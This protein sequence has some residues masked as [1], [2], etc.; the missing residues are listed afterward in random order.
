MK[1][2]NSI[3]GALLVSFPMFARVELPS[4]I[5]SGMVLQRN[6]SVMLWGKSSPYAR[7]KIDTGWDKACYRTES[8]ADGRW[9]VRVATCNAGGPYTVTISDGTPVTL[10]N[11][12]LGEVWI[13]S[14]QSNMEMP[15]KGFFNQPTAEPMEAISRAGQYPGLRLFTVPKNRSDIPLDSCGGRWLESTPRSV[16]DFSATAY[17]F[18]RTL[19]DFLGVPVGLVNVSYGGSAIEEW[20]PREVIDKMGDIKPATTLNIQKLWNGMLLPVVPFTA[21]GFI[22]YQG[23]ANRKAWM[24]YARLQ[25]AQIGLWRQTWE[26]DSMPFYITQIAPFEYDGKNKRTIP[27]LVNSQYEAAAMTPLCAVAATT[28]LGNPDCIHPGQKRQVG[29]R[30]AWLA[31]Q[32]DY[33]IDGLPAPAPTYKSMEIK[34]GKIL[35]SLNDGG[36]RNTLAI[37]DTNG[38]IRIGGFEIAGED[39]VW[40]PATAEILKGRDPLI[41]VSSPDV[42]EP[43]AVRYAFHNVSPDANVRTVWGQPLVPFRTDDWPIPSDEF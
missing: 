11:V 13:C 25:Q 31:L 40:Y 27:L 12:L 34:D 14:G 1:K 7:I 30:L 20:M 22:W 29:E 23:E 3:V 32:R 2:L 24:N 21:K 16:G 42:P 39:R 6:D 38:K 43:V 15:V 4:V 9:R 8:G 10:D 28:D 35:I 37:Y 26:R 18:G 5:G 41:E 33:G 36:G 17:Y 19:S